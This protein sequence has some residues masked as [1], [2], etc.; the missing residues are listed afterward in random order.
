MGFSPVGGW[1]DFGRLRCGFGFCFELIWAVCGLSWLFVG[2]AGYLVDF[3]LIDLLVTLDLREFGFGV[4][5]N[6]WF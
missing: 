4:I 3:G 2:L 1:L 6:F 5:C